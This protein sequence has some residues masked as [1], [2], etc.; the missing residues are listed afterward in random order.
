MAIAA[1][2]FAGAC[3]LFAQGRTRSPQVR[4]RAKGGARRCYRATNPAG[5]SNRAGAVSSDSG[6]PALTPLAGAGAVEHLHF[7]HFPEFR[8]HSGPMIPRSPHLPGGPGKSRRA[9]V[10]EKGV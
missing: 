2:V 8:E 7:H 9:T 5:A 6:I 3:P 10:G 4:S 1:L